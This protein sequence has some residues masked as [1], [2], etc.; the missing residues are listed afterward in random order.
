MRTGAAWLEVWISN[1]F[2]YPTAPFELLAVNAEMHPVYV[3]EERERLSLSRGI[4]AGRGSSFKGG[5]KV[6]A[7]RDWSDPWRMDLRFVGS[8][9]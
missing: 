3:R 5:T 9:P 2:E 6:G 4:G 7:V 1:Q 8:S